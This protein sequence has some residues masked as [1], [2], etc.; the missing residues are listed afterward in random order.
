MPYES[1]KARFSLCS[2]YFICVRKDLVTLCPE[3][4][5]LSSFFFVR[6]LDSFSCSPVLGRHIYVV[7]RRTLAR[8]LAESFYQLRTPLS[9]MSRGPA[10]WNTT[11]NNPALLKLV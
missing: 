2:Q 1:A 7:E 5:T 8:G 11:N 9:P 4:K 10:S 3:K 6:P